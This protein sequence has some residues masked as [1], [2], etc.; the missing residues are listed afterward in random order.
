MPVSGALERYLVKPGSKVDLGSVET[1]EKF[2]FPHGGKQEHLPYLHELRAELAGLQEKLF[3]QAKKKVLIVIQAMDAGG[4]DGCVKSVF[5]QV[6]QQGVRVEAF[7]RPTE[8][9]MGHDF[10]WRVHAKCPGA[11]YISV[12]NRSHYEDVIAVRVKNIF[13]EEV[14]RKRYQ[15]ILDFEQMLADEG[16]KIIKIFLCISKEEQK[17]RLEGRLANPLKYWKFEPQDLED[18]ARWDEFMTAYEDLIAH[19]SKEHAPWYVVPADR[20]W[21]RN[22]VVSRIIIDTMKG[23][24]LDFPKQDWDPSAIVVPD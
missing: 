7:K 20:K 13:P 21:Y 14:W 8:E 3:S 11:G 24:D 16:T 6:D 2:L 10:L 4:K 19:T 5:A 22:L 12:F 23:M 18:R 1:R 9:E 17:E 15:H